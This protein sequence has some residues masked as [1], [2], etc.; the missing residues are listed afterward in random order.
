MGDEMLW[1]AALP[2][3]EQLSIRNA[4]QPA[5]VNSVPRGIAACSR[6][7]YLNFGLAGHEDVVA[8]VPISGPYLARLR[9]LFWNSNR[10]ESIPTA[11]ADAT[12]LTEL[13]LTLA[14]PMARQFDFLMQLPELKPLW[15]NVCRPSNSWLKFVL[16][17]QRQRAAVEV[18]SIDVGGV[19]YDDDGGYSESSDED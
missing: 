10:L 2:A 17:L 7:T 9:I 15:L 16:D 4:L 6:L 13:R 11:L 14:R 8:L 12:C 19:F 3:L 18:L 5:G 1:L